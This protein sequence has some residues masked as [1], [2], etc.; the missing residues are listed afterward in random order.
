MVYN[1]TNHNN[2][3]HPSLE[4]LKLTNTVI[5]RICNDGLSRT[6]EIQYN[7]SKF[8]SSGSFTK[9]DRQIHPNTSNRRSFLERYNASNTLIIYIIGNYSNNLSKLIFNI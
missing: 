7:S 8:D 5:K 1:I 9:E 3:N 2:T 6:S 4:N